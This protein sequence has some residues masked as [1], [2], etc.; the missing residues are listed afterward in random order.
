[1]LDRLAVEKK[2][3]TV[4][5]TYPKDDTWWLE[6]WS[7]DR[8]GYL[9]LDG[10]PSV[11]DTLAEAATLVHAPVVHIEDSRGLPLNLVQSL[12]ERGLL[13]VLSIYDFTFFC[14][15]PQLIEMP[16]GRFCGFSNDLKRCDACLREID[17]DQR[18]PQAEYRRVGANALYAANLVIYPSQYMQR[19]HRTLF[20]ERQPE[21][22]EVVIAPATSRQPAARA[23]GGDRPNVAFIGGAEIAAGPFLI[24]PIMDVIRKQRPK[25]SG[26]VYGTGDNEMLQRVGKTKRVTVRGYF[27]KGT[28][29][30]LL[31]RDRIG[32][33]VLPAISPEA[34]GLVVDECLSAGVPVVAL[35]LGAVADRLKYWEVGRVVALSEGVEGLADAAAN[36]LHLQDTVPQSIIRALPPIDRAAQRHI[37]MY[38][39]AR[40]RAQKEK[41]KE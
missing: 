13:T 21:Q 36:V 30:S 24:P 18:H 10:K 25:A 31:A 29:P 26:F 2:K 28:L 5:L 17:P 9:P 39:F 38:R 41:S 34:Y 33:A 32:V 8:A 16:Q 20:P 4:A 3:R 35:E 6:V 7:G 23:K 22:R 19:R 11:V 1:M 12:Q 37:E 40:I 14:R 15:R 27:R